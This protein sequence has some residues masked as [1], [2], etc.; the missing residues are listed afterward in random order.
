[1]K[2]DLA[3]QLYY[4][5]VDVIHNNPGITYRNVATLM[6]KS[7]QYVGKFIREAHRDGLVCVDRSTYPHT[8]YSP[9]YFKANRPRGINQVITYLT[10]YSHQNYSASTHKAK[11]RTIVIHV[12]KRG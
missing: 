5:V 3:A 2:R 9:E 4:G 10:Q 12:R 1:M 7:G 6:N 11:D 8:L